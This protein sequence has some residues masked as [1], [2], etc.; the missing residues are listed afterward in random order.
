MWGAG[1][2]AEPSPRSTALLDIAAPLREGP[3][4]SEVPLYGRFLMSEVPLFKGGLLFLMSE[5]P[6]H[7]G[8]CCFL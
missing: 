6:L 1:V 8:G 2:R 4:L 3:T 7:S 5:V